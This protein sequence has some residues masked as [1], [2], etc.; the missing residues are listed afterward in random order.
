MIA[1]DQKADAME[2]ERAADWDESSS[3]TEA[4]PAAE[5]ASAEPEREGC[6]SAEAMVCPCSDGRMPPGETS[7]PAGKIYTEC[8]DSRR[9]HRLGKQASSTPACGPAPA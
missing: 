4:T 8:A 5:W 7:M 6:I 9:K 3:Q 1:R 2:A